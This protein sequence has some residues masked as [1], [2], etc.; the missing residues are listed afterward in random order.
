MLGERKVPKG[1][2]SPGRPKEVERTARRE[3]GR[4]KGAAILLPWDPMAAVAISCFIKILPRVIDSRR[5]RALALAAR[6]PTTISSP[7]NNLESFMTAV[8]QGGGGVNTERDVNAERSA[9]P[10]SGIRRVRT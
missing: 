6:S 2:S 5:Q 1:V 3:F 7:V 9:H 10:M 8:S 4:P